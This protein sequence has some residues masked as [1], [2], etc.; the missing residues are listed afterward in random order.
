MYNL[1]IIE[2]DLVDQMAIQRMV[3]K[4]PTQYQIELT[5]SIESAFQ[6]LE[7]THF[8]V[9]VSDY[10]L[11][12]G[13]ALDLLNAPEVDVPVIIITGNNDQDKI[14]ELKKAGAHE[15]LLKDNQLRYITS[16]PHIIDAL[17]YRTKSGSSAHQLEQQIPGPSGTIIP[18]DY[19]ID[20]LIDTFEGNKPFIVSMINTFLEQNPIELK[21]LSNA[22][23]K[24][25]FQ[26]V[27]RIA[28]KI[29]SGYKLMGMNQQ[30][31]LAE[32]IEQ[33]SINPANADGAIQFLI[34]QLVNNS[35]KVYQFLQSQVEL[36]EA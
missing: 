26:M 32:Q 15:V 33:I 1:L 27:S 12:D 29:K 23:H 19:N 14:E 5:D 30:V 16:L 20:H 13:T 7:E 22:L 9:I 31:S 28:H 25:D 24:A 4:H 8:D 10:F 35:Q 6:N 34:S 3:K 18:D 21:R 2:D 17:I 36:M 11:N